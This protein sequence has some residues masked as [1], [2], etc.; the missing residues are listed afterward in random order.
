MRLKNVAFFLTPSN[1]CSS[2]DYPLITYLHIFVFELATSSDVSIQ[3]KQPQHKSSYEGIKYKCS[4]HI[5]RIFYFFMSF[6]LSK[7][8]STYFLDKT[9]FF[10][11]F[12]I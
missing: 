5:N 8:F 2:S 10:S 9:A 7:L 3:N 1:L 12:L 4:F 11:F 6:L